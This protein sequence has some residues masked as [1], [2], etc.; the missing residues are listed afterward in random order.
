MV[1]QPGIRPC[2]VED[3]P[4]VLEMWREADATPSVTDSLVQLLPLVESNSL[5]VAEVDS[6]VVGS[7]IAGWDGWRGNLYRLAV[8][9]A[10]RRRG[11]G[12]ALVQAAER[13]LRERG[14]RRISILVERE[15]S[16][17]R[18]FWDGA[19][20]LGYAPHPRMKRYVKTL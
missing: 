7:I 15:D 13:L 16:L 17:A 18:A 3:C 2:T 1:F 14:A 19:T 11:V 10:H 6:R 5:L 12:T 9:P 4:A 8:S 20:E